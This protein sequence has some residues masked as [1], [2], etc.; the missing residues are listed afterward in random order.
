EDWVGL[1]QHLLAM[2]NPPATVVAVAPQQTRLAEAIRW[3][4]PGYGTRNVPVPAALLNLGMNTI[5]METGL[6]LGS[7]RNRSMVLDNIGYSFR[8]PTIGEA[9][10]AVSL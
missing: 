7:T 8:F 4:A 2:P 5:R 10:D 6:L 9:G 3:L 1:V